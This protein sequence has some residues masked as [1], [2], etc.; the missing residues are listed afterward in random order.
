M[1]RLTSI[2]YSNTAFNIAMLLLRVTAGV[3]VLPYGYNKLVHFAEKKSTFMNFLGMGSTLSL[4][5]VIFA[6]FFCS[7]F[8]IAGIFTR[9]VAIPLIVVMSVAI[10]KAHNA[11]IFGQAEKPLL[12]LVAFLTILLCG[13]GKISVDGMMK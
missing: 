12:F 8:L 10:L 6:E 13:P 2:N 9:L 11:D 1:K 7:M 5:L 3:L 4:S